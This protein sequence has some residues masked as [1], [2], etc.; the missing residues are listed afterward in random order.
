[1]TSA[2]RD[3]GK[4][5]GAGAKNHG[6]GTWQAS[7]QQGRDLQSPCSKQVGPNYRYHRRKFV[8]EVKR[9]PYL[10]LIRPSPDGSDRSDG[11]VTSDQS[12]RQ[13]M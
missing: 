1:M 4:C 5:A 8:V 6:L 3:A 13:K 2:K 9:S 7:G 11:S 10:S 12:H